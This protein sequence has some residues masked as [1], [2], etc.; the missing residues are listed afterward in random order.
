MIHLSFL[1]FLSPQPNLAVLVDL[2]DLKVQ[3]DLG[4]LVFHHLPLSPEFRHVQVSPLVLEY[5]Q[6]LEESKHVIEKCQQYKTGT[7]CMEHRQMPLNTK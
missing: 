4:V 6:T 1:C 3:A 7:K 2:S 5:Q